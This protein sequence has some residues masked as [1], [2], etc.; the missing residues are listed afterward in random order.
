MRLNSQHFT[1]GA[2]VIVSGLLWFYYSEYQRKDKDY[3]DLNTKHQ[4]QLIA[5]NKQQARIQHLAELE[6]KHIRELD[7]AKTEIDTLRADVAA[8]RRKLRIQAVCPVREATSSGSVVDAG[9]PQLTEAARQDYYDLLRMM[10]E[11]ERQTK[12]LQDYVGSEV[13]HNYGN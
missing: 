9:T 11:N 6:T 13:R 7:N 12:Y 10:A 5:I 2:L 4:T 3:T 1:L 8:G